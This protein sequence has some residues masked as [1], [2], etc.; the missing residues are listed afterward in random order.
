[1]PMDRSKVRRTKVLSVRLS[2]SDAALLQTV[3]RMLLR[4]GDRASTLYRVTAVLA[5]ST[6]TYPTVK[7]STAASTLTRAQ[8]ELVISGDNLA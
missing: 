2:Q 1:M 6:S 8:H 3:Q 4:M 5:S 7:G